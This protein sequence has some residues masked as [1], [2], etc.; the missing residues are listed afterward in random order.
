MLHEIVI[1]IR[2]QFGH[3]AKRVVRGLEHLSS[4]LPEEEK[5]LKGLQ[6]SWRGTACQG[7]MLIGQG[8]MSS[9][10]KKGDLE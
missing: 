5:N 4:G 1:T 8:M 2:L 9:S 10:R 7:S 6:E 3:L